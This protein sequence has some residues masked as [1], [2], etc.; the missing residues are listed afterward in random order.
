MD[1][2]AAIHEIRAFLIRKKR[3]YSTLPT[4]ENIYFIKNSQIEL[5]NLIH[6]LSK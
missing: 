1:I 5:K 3:T 6:T 2:E 4:Q